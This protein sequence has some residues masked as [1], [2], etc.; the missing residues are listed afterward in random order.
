MGNQSNIEEGFRIMRN[1]RFF[2]SNRDDIAMELFKN[3][4]S[5]LHGK[6]FTKSQVIRAIIKIALE[7][8]L[9]EA[10]SIMRENN[11]IRKEARKKWKN[12]NKES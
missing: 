3:K 9:D 6:T 8:E 10:L 5:K 12:T 1:H 7:P 11:K 4:L 2:I